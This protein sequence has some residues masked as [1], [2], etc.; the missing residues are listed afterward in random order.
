MSEAGGMRGG[1]GEMAVNHIGRGL[2]LSR[3]DCGRKSRVPTITS[4]LLPGSCDLTTSG[5]QLVLHA[6]SPLDLHQSF[7]VILSMNGR[8]S[9]RSAK[10]WLQRSL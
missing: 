7:R 9:I 1:G 6:V 2:L 8:Q 4:R 5:L 3:K 10:V